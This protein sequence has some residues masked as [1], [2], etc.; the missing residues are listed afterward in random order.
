MT[1][2]TF[3]RL[4]GVIGNSSVLKLAEFATLLDNLIS[5]AIA[6]DATIEG[7]SS[8]RFCVQKTAEAT[9]TLTRVS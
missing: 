7:A 1:Q 9:F 6:A 8:G 3:D 2:S 5:E 4:Q